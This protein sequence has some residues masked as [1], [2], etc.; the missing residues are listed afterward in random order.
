MTRF[1][2][3]GIFIWCSLLGSTGLYA[4]ATNKIDSIGNVGIGTTSPGNNLHVIGGISAGDSKFYNSIQLTDSNNGN[5]QS[6]IWAGAAN[7]LY[8]GVGGLSNANAKMIISNNGNIGIGTFEPDY[9][10]DVNGHSRILG[11]GDVLTLDKISN[12]YPALAF[13]GATNKSVIEG[14]DSYLNFSIS[15]QDIARLTNSGNVGIGTTS[16]GNKLHVVGGISAGDSKFY[17]S[18]QLTDAINGTTQSWIW[19]GA[20]NQLN[21]GVGTLSASNTKMVVTNNGY[22]GIGTNTPI[23]KLDV[24]GNT[25]LQGN[26]LM[27]DNGIYLTSGGDYLLGNNGSGN[28]TLFTRGKLVLSSNG[29]NIGQSLSFVNNGITALEIVPG[30]NIGIGTTSPSEKLSV[31]GNISTKKCIV[32]QT[33]W[34]DYV[35]NEGY[36]LRPLNQVEKFIKDNKHLPEVPSAKEVEEKGLDLGTNQAVLLKKIEEL[37]LYI[38][39]LDKE[40]KLLRKE[41]VEIKHLLVHNK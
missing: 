7:Q 32:T 33:G 31:N 28:S 8:L 24:N 21:L 39:E 11:E 2:C 25:N 30:G 17:N 34:S 37:S 16:P 9:K 10:L 3:S 6:W 36:K 40:N 13:T 41:V 35:F 15:G 26:L 29:N 23:Q 18:I 5:T 1:I 14:G 19:S 12:H 22:I 27:N 4:Q 20:A 38:I